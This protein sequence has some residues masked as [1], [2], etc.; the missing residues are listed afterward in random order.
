MCP[1]SHHQACSGG[2]I[3]HY[4]CGEKKEYLLSVVK[5]S[6]SGWLVIYA[7]SCLVM[8]CHSLLLII[9]GLQ[10]NPTL[11]RLSLLY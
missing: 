5:V 1:Q 9:W 7:L 8:P 11:L 6:L 3:L 2:G 4:I 10:T